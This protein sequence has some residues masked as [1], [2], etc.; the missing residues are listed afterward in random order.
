MSG[1]DRTRHD[2]DIAGRLATLRRIESD[3]FLL[4]LEQATAHE[5]L[6]QLLG[7]YQAGRLELQ[8]A[9]ARA[10]EILSR[11][12]GAAYAIGGK[13]TLECERAGKPP[14]A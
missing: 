9:D 12:V 13:V 3:V 1:H 14:A 10:G 5:D 6:A 8:T 11:I 4:A 2:P 7:D